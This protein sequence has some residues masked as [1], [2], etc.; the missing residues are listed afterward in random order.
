[1][2]FRLND[3][4]LL[5][6][7]VKYCQLCQ[8]LSCMSTT[9]KYCQLCQLLSTICQLLSYTVNYV[10]Y[11][12]VLSTI[13]Q[14]LS[15][16]VNYVNYCQVRTVNYMSSTVNYSQTLIVST[17]FSKYYGLVYVSTHFKA[18][19]IIRVPLSTWIRSTLLTKY[20]FLLPKE[21]LIIRVRL[22]IN[23]CQLYVNYRHVLSTMSSTVN[24]VNCHVL[25][26]MS[27]TVKA[28]STVVN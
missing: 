14:L 26:T 9:V 21:V 16:T 24:Y 18:V 7:T 27:T 6:S 22:Y 1:M 19:L 15:C 2:G 28:L 11:C 4:H 17:L 5:S 25:S 23:Y 10:N 12:Q 8:V 20:Q 13:C 3:Y